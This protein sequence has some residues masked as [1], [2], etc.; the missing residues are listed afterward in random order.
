MIAYKYEYKDRQMPGTISVLTANVHQTEAIQALA[1]EAYGVAPELAVDW[2]AAEQYNSRIEHFPEGQL[3]AVEDATGRVIG[4][5]SSM[6][7]RY[8]PEL[9]FVEDWDR[10]TG[11][12]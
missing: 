12:G 9:T 4:M 5:T 8:N 6:R 3:V 2:F 7:F 10:T 11:F 1:G